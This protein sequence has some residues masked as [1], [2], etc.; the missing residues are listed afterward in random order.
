MKRVSAPSRWVALCL[1]ALAQAVSLNSCS[2]LEVK[3][4]SSTVRTAEWCG[5]LSETATNHVVLLRVDE[6]PSY[7]GGRIGGVLLSVWPKLADESIPSDDIRIAATNYDL[8]VYESD[9]F[10]NPKSDIPVASAN[11]WL[12]LR[13]ATGVL[14][15][16]GYYLVRVT[17]SDAEG[18]PIVPFDFRAKAEFVPPEE[19]TPRHGVKALGLFRNLDSGAFPATDDPETAVME[20]D[21]DYVGLI[22]S[23]DGLTISSRLFLPKAVTQPVPTVLQLS[24]LPG[25]RFS[26]LG[27]TGQRKP[28]VFRALT[29]AER[30]YG[31]LSYTNRGVQASCGLRPAGWNTS[32]VP[33]FNTNYETPR[34][35]R[36]TGKPTG[37]PTCLRGWTHFFLERDYEGRDARHLLGVLVDYGIAN[38]DR[39]AMGGQSL[40]GFQS[41][42]AATELPWKTP[43]GGRTIQL[44]AA[45]SFGGGSEAHYVVAPNGRASDEVDQTRSHDRPYGTYRGILGLPVFALG[46]DQGVRW[47]TLDPEETH[48]FVSGWEAFWQAGEPYDTSDVAGFT[49]ER[50]AA[51]FRGKAAYHADAYF[52]AL[53]AG[54]LPRKVPIFAAQG[55]TDHLVIPVQTL[56]LYRKLKAA[57]P[58]YPI[59]MA[60]ADIGHWPA[61]D[62]DNANDPNNN[63]VDPGNNRD[64]MQIRDHLLGLAIRFL[65][66]YM[67]GTG[68]P[69]AARITS[70]EASYP[71]PFNPI[72]PAIVSGND[73]DETRAGVVKLKGDGSRTTISGPPKLAEEAPAAALPGMN[74][75]IVQPAGTYLGLSEW[76]WPVG[77][78]GYTLLGLPRVKLNYVLTG[79]DATVIAKLWDV[80]E[81]GNRTLVTRGLY[82]LSVAGGDPQGAPGNPAK[83]SFQLFGNHYKLR[84]G[85]KVTL[86]L[87]Q[88]DVPYL[89]PN[90]LPSTIEFSNPKLTLPA[91]EFTNGEGGVPVLVTGTG[92]MASILAAGAQGTFDFDV[93]DGAPPKGKLVY[94]DEGTGDVI[95]A[96]SFEELEITESHATLTGLAKVNGV[97]GKRFQI[98]V[99]DLSGAAV[100]APDLFTI[101][102]LD[103]GGYVNSGPV[104]SG[105]IQINR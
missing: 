84:E 92:T 48:S 20:A 13:E 101:R 4:V 41:L 36:E 1:L 80:D 105:G 60:F 47:N 45:L 52:D 87:S 30:G 102:I 61:Q 51:A 86:E 32:S 98:D 50:I 40:G 56:Q 82:R 5:S 67:L 19:W 26:D 28:S 88:T 27:I 69:P 17:Y 29:L 11:H 42:N 104:S 31:T 21:R 54:T 63:D 85:H 100:P 72:L 57:D 71:T 91:V 95:E 97:A 44:A 15:A 70:L 90:K 74:G 73:W 81:F 35:P 23:F 25:L 83:M 10:G 39:L 79:I 43:L 2:D 38:P 96:T 34:G 64:Y 22:E 65:D 59:W 62:P 12:Y 66:Y 94:R 58:D 3:T 16:S 37:D 46:N 55:W 6:P 75:P 78:G 24:G 9:E 103:P 76:S 7:W 49:A 89:R 99:D 93:R 18:T 33:P 8:Y 68:D 14:R 77:T 53:R